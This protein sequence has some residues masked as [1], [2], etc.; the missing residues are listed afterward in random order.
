MGERRRSIAPA[1]AAG[2]HQ[3]AR[4]RRAGARSEGVRQRPRLRRPARP[5]AAAGGG[6]RQAEEV[7]VLAAAEGGYRERLAVVVRIRSGAGGI[8]PGD[9]G[10]LSIAREETA[11]TPA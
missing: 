1:A 6:D 11:L 5:R 8:P 4:A 9:R 10:I 3:P 7:R 2:R